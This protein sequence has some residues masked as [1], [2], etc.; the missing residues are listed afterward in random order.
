MQET[1]AFFALDSSVF[2]AFAGYA[3]AMK[4]NPVMYNTLIVRSQVEYSTTQ[5]VIL[6]CILEIPAT[7]QR[8]GFT[9]LDTLL[10][11]L[12]AELLEFQRQIIPLDQ[13]S[14]KGPAVTG[15]TSCAS[16]PEP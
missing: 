7:G 6:R 5:A 1:L 9:D 15:S 10:V 12:R 11:A 16:D 13:K 4:V 3:R 2:V 8:H 14:P